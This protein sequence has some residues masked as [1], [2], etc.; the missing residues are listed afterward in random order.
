MRMSRREETSDDRERQR[1]RDD[2]KS[3]SMIEARSRMP[4][5]RKNGKAREGKEEKTH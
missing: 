2:V 4:R 3:D 1:E 5:N